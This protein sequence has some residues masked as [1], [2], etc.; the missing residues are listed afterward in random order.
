M[1]SS[2]KKPRE[3]LNSKAQSHR[4][5]RI[6]RKAKAAW[7]VVPRGDIVERADLVRQLPA[8]K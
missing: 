5:Q 8:C 1:I 2:A 7:L 4:R 3:H 6:P